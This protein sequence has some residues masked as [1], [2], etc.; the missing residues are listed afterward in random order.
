[1]E[2]A[3]QVKIALQ[4]ELLPKL[5]EVHV[6]TGV[7]IELWTSIVGEGLSADEP[8]T[9]SMIGTD[10]LDSPMII[11]DVAIIKTAQ[12]IK[13]SHSTMASDLTILSEFSE[14]KVEI[15]QSE[16][17]NFGFVVAEL[18]Q[19]L[20]EQIDTHA[21]TIDD[22]GTCWYVT[23]NMLSE[24]ELPSMDFDDS[25]LESTVHELDLLISIARELVRSSESAKN[26][27]LTALN[28]VKEK[29]VDKSE[30]KNTQS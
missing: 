4:A 17:D 26:T 5:A 6:N 20:L 1:M 2:P 24:T 21:A 10:N 14:L 28:L 8:N 7:N 29:Y 23:G 12:C 15:P 30:S 19:S 27:V 9:V 13:I 3:L 11:L 16:L 22:L 25:E 18:M